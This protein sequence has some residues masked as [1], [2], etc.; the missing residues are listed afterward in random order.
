MIDKIA[1]ECRIILKEFEKEKDE[2]PL[3]SIY[4]HNLFTV[5]LLEKHKKRYKFYSKRWHNNFQAYN[6]ILSVK[7]IF[8]I[9]QE[10]LCLKNHCYY[11]NN[12]IPISKKIFI[13]YFQH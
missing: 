13:E 3:K 2:Y 8:A 7:H 9:S 1:K 12:F 10:F 11:K 6:N 5:E 4:F